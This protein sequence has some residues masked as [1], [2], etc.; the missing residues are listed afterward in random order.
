MHRPLLREAS[1]QPRIT[2]APLHIWQPPG[3]PPW[4][5]I[6]REGDA[7]RMRFPALADFLVCK[8]G[9]VECLPAPGTDEHTLQHLYLNQVIPAV[10]SMQ[11]R[12]VFHASCI[13]IDNGA[14]AFLGVSG[15]GK[16]TLATHLA[17]QG[18]ALIT[19]DGLEL[20]WRD[21]AYLAV[22]ST[23]SVRLWKDSRSALLPEVAASPCASY[24]PKERFQSAGL[25]PFAEDPL[26]LRRAY[27]LGDGSARDITLSALASH[28]AHMA[29]V[30][31]SFM[32]D[33]HDKSRMASHFEQVTRLV[34][35]GL[36]YALDYPRRYDMLPA[37]ADALRKH[38][39]RE[40]QAASRD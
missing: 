7:Y 23:A 1:V 16:S 32:L 19:D 13:A 22:P 3:E 35:L 38:A 28:E 26:P 34:Q 15:R 6:Y 36:A 10:L 12:P 33:A 9:E 8:D 20:Q 4:C 2:D 24:T 11:D 5:L 30:R 39:S 18:H 14:V 21:E 31:H 40:G 25:L 37:V 29:W 27:F 17:L